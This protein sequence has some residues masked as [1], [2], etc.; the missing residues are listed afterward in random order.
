MENASWVNCEGKWSALEGERRKTN[1]EVGV[2]E[3]GVETF[4]D[5]V[6]LRLWSNL[7]SSV[8]HLHVKSIKISS[9]KVSMFQNQMTS[10]DGWGWRA[11]CSAGNWN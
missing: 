1:A 8:C 6:I 11:S 9:N 5:E 4:A 3:G 10:K 7:A 2:V